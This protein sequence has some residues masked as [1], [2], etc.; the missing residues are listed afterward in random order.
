MSTLQNMS[1]SRRLGIVM[2]VLLCITFL[3]FAGNYL[4]VNHKNPSPAQEYISAIFG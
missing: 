3:E 1:I 4:W 2:A